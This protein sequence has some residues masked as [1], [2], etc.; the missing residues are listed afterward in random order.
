MNKLKPGFQYINRKEIYLRGIKDIILMGDTGCTGFNEE[1]KKILDRILKIKTNLFIIL[2]DFAYTGKQEEFRE[3]INFCNKRADVP[4]F[5]LCG[6]HD[7][8]DYPKVPPLA[9]ITT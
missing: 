9:N 3:V 1:S 4:I 8:P 7:M 2:G 5:T 6:N